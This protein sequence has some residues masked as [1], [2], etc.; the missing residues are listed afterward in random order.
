M[1]RP[2][3]VRRIAT[4]VKNLDG[5]YEKI[6]R[7]SSFVMEAEANLEIRPHPRLQVV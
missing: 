4:N 2:R 5:Y 6:Y 3:V 7:L 1:K